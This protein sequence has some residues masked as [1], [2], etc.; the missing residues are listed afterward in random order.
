MACPMAIDCSEP[1]EVALVE[2]AQLGNGAVFA[3]VRGRV[4]LM[5]DG[6]AAVLEALCIEIPDKALM[7][8][9]SRRKGRAIELALPKK[10]S[11]DI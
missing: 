4:F 11:G 2:A 8:R 6:V 10:N 5:Y 9:R 7:K 3:T 1:M